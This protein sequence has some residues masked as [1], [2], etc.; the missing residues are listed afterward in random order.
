M[1]PLRKTLIALAL[2]AVCA[3]RASVQEFDFEA[4]SAKRFPTP[5]PVDQSVVATNFT[6]RFPILNPA[7]GMW[8]LKFDYSLDHDEGHRIF[9]ARARVAFGPKVM[10]WGNDVRGPTFPDSGVRRDVLYPWKCNVEV[11]PGM[12]FADVSFELFGKGDF[13]VAAVSLE[14][15]PKDSSPVTIELPFGGCLDGVFHIG[16]GQTGVPVFAWRTNLADDTQPARF[17]CRVTIPPGFAF[18]DASHADL[19]TLAITRCSDGGSVVVYRVHS[20]PPA[21]SN[22]DGDRFGIVVRADGGQGSEGVMTIVGELDGRVVSRPVSLR[23]FASAPVKVDN[24]PSRYANAAYL[25]GSYADFPGPGNRA[26]AQTLRAAGVTWIMP[27]AAAVTNNPS[28][29]AMWREE[30]MRRITPDGSCFVANGFCHDGKVLCPCSFY[31]DD[32][33][34]RKGLRKL[35]KTALAGCDGMWSNWEPYEHLVRRRLCPRCSEAER[36]LDAAAY[37]RLRSSEHGRVVAALAA[38]VA[39]AT[40]SDVGFIPGVYWPELGPGHEG[41]DFT[42]EIHTDDYAS[43]LSYVNAFGPYV[44]WNTSARYVPEPGRALAY[45]SVARE[46]MRQVEEDYSPD[47]RPALMSFPLGLSGMDWAS[48]PEWLELALESFFFNGWSCTAPWSFP[49][50][51]DARFLAAFAR[52]TELSAKWEDYVWN[53]ARADGAVRVKPRGTV[54]TRPWID[55]TYLPALRDVPL[56][57]HAAWEKGGERIVA[58]FNF[59][60]TASVV[61]DVSAISRSQT[62]HVPPSSCRVAFFPRK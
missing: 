30:G 10:P 3:A 47:V 20:R 48:K 29:V 52:A 27:N 11:M 1:R 6:Q 57:Q 38:D 28:L 59:D 4:L 51:G 36:G 40:S 41:F 7:G 9:G 23:L 22:M 35:F 44:R 62:L 25:G 24:V 55:R 12:E 53:G 49:S 15:I 18:V 13:R 60:E 32:S 56:L 58:V 17:G 61:C 31:R 34:V 8:R 43:E 16:A 5:P 50:G 21:F 54:Q 19:R 37:H 42:R 46:V 45:F 2:L 26:L 14:E 33:P 39:A